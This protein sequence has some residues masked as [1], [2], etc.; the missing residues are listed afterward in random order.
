MLAESLAIQPIS[1]D[2]VIL[3][4]ASEFITEPRHPLS[5]IR[6]RVIYIARFTADGV[7]YRVNLVS[8]NWIQP[9]PQ[10]AT[11]LAHKGFP[12]CVI[13]ALCSKLSAD[14]SLRQL[15]DSL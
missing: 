2:A 11:R 5:F 6:Q 7:A 9:L 1:S 15:E 12:Q 14:P 13:V 4:T 3:V 8:R 10:V